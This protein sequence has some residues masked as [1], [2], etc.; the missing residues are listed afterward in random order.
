MKQK[1]DRYAMSIQ[2][3]WKSSGL[4]RHS[5][6]DLSVGTGPQTDVGGSFASLIHFQ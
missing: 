1:T 6:E 5:R 3:H 2:R 4:N